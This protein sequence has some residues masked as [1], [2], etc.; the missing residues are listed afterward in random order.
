M[1]VDWRVAGGLVNATTSFNT[2]ESILGN[3]STLSTGCVW[4]DDRIAMAFDDV[5]V[6]LHRFA[7]RSV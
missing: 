7:T 5:I 6:Q 1:L 4:I 2:F 3:A